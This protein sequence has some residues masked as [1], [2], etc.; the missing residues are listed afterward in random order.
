MRND[1]QIRADTGDLMGKE[2]TLPLLDY[3]IKNTVVNASVRT[4][5]IVF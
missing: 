5:R 4:I 2:W 1:S 3:D